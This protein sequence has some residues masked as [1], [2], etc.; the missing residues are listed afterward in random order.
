MPA[1]QVYPQ[2][3]QL[4]D[5]RYWIDHEGDYGHNA[6]FLDA[7]NSAGLDPNNPG[8][9]HPDMATLA[10][11]GVKIIAPPLWMLV[12]TNAQQQIVPSAYAIAA[13]DS[14]MDII[15]WS[16]ERSGPLAAGGGWYYQSITP[17]INNDGDTLTLLD[18]LARE[19]GVIG[20]FSDWPAT[21]T[22]YANCLKQIERA[23]R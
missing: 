12:T 17:A 23:S 4:E 2:S 11:Y 19:V 21:T 1:E 7:R 13:R 15:T 10:G 5:V 18:V 9:W 3:F 20:V 14:G 8:I 22:F 6:I 16:L